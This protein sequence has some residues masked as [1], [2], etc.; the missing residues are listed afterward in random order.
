MENIEWLDILKVIISIITVVLAII[1][2]IYGNDLISKKRDLRKSYE[3]RINTFHR[4]ILQ[5][6]TTS[7]MLK[8]VLEKLIKNKPSDFRTLPYLIEKEG[9]IAPSEKK[10]I[11][12]IVSVGKE[13][14]NLINENA[15]LILDNNLREEVGILSRHLRIFRF[16]AQNSKEYDSNEF[17]EFVY[18]REVNEMIEREYRAILRMLQNDIENKYLEEIEIGCKSNKI[19][20]LCAQIVGNPDQ[21]LIHKIMGDSIHLYKRRIY[22]ENE[23]FAI[24]PSIGPLT[25]GHV[26]IVPKKHFNSI[27]M[28]EPFDELDIYKNEMTKLLNIIFQNP[29]HF[30]EHGNSSKTKRLLCSTE[31]AHLHAFPSKIENY[32][33]VSS[34]IKTFKWTAT[35]IKFKEV[36]N[37]VNDT[38]YLFYETPNGKTYLKIFNDNKIESQFFRKLVSEIDGKRKTW[39]WKQFPRLDT[40]KDTI[41]QLEKFQNKIEK[42]EYYSQRRL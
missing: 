12:E 34:M 4:P 9:N 35:D 26:L 24:I 23:K 36:S 17:K 5:A 13:I 11:E 7:K 21:D 37:Y 1:G 30:F 19:C 6:F 22:F 38:E 15:G 42:K 10:V 2:V 16:V 27:S 33:E 31:H 41:K 28:V 14:E 25:L 39:N 29:I 20:Y 40:L 32:V 3:D 18:P 8:D